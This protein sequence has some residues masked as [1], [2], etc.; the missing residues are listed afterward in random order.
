MT[1]RSRE[2]LR[3]AVAGLESRAK[4]RVRDTSDVLKDQGHYAVDKWRGGIGHRP[5]TSMAVAFAAGWLLA[6]AVERRCRYP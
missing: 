6:S 2:R 5:L 3:T 1:M 4:D